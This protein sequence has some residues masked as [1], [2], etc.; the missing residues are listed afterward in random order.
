MN[1]LMSRLEDFW[2]GLAPRER[3][4]VGGAGA[5]LG[6]SLIAFAVVMP[7]LGLAD[8]A[9]QRVETAEN[10]IVAMQRLQREH[11]EIEAR[12]R[13]VEDRIRNQQGRRNI[14]TVLETLARQSQVAIKSMDPRQASSDERYQETKVEVKLEK[15]SLEQAVKYLHNIEV[16]DRQ[17]S[18]KS[19]R[20]KTRKDQ[21]KLLDVTFTVSSFDPA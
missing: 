17:L 1:E 19:L 21:S 9:A 18:V 6:V 20:V 16:S 14:N 7:V 12:L 5:A 11:S 2:Q 13:R 8:D 15:V 3:I 10:Q 4:L